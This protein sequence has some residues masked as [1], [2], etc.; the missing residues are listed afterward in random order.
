M[1]D[2]L[3]SGLDAK[4][5]KNKQ[6]PRSFIIHLPNIYTYL[7]NEINTCQ[8]NIKIVETIIKCIKFI[9]NGVTPDKRLRL[10]MNKHGQRSI[11]MGIKEVLG[12]WF[13]LALKVKTSISYL[14]LCLR[15]VEPFS[16]W[17]RLFCENR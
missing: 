1:N 7:K 14:Q 4:Q 6:T 12:V 2:A 13:F 8:P 16:L 9:M 5:I 10:G 11:E 15:S 3:N 17:G